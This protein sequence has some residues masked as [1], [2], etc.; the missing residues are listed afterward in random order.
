MV[1]IHSVQSEVITPSKVI[2]GNW[3]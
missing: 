2:Q 3:F 1:F